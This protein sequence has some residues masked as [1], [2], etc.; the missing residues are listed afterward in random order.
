MRD[1]YLA[2]QVD[3]AAGH[4][5]YAFLNRCKVSIALVCSR[6]NAACV[7]RPVGKMVVCEPRGRRLQQTGTSSGEI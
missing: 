2:A 1:T 7:G 5:K 4:R 3:K 6:R